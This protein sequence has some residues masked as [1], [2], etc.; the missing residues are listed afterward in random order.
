L[1]QGKIAI[2]RRPLG[3]VEHFATCALKQ[4]QAAC[5]GSSSYKRGADATVQ[6][7]ETIGFYSLSEAV[8]CT[9]VLQ[10]EVVGLALESHFDR[11]EGILDVL[12]DD[13]GDLVDV[14]IM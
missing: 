3:R 1:G 11:I 5:F 8:N 14:S 6:P 7:Q 10:W 13:T 4:E 9:L 2:A 12:A